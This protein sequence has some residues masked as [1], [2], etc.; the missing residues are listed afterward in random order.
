MKPCISLIAALTLSSLAAC[1][2]PVHAYPVVT[3]WR[4]PQW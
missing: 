4:Y 1:D 3:H 2:D